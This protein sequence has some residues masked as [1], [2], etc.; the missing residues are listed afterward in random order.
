MKLYHT[1]GW[2]QTR[3]PYEGLIEFVENYDNV[4]PGFGAIFVSLDEK[5]ISGKIAKEISEEML[6]TGKSAKKIVQ[7]R[8]LLQIN[9]ENILMEVIRKVLDENSASVEDYLNGKEKTFTFFVGQI[10][11]NTRGKANP[12]LANKLL[13]EELQKKKK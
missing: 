12:Q 6:Q 13:L 4:H 11:R 3:N 1:F 10:M 8:G 2:S 7:T 9:D 5:I